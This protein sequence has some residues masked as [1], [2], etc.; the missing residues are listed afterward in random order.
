MS[1]NTRILVSLHV[2]AAVLIT[3]QQVF[4]GTQTNNFTIFRESFWHLVNDQDL[5]AAYP[6]VTFDF[7]KYS[8]TN[9]LLFAPFAVVPHS[10]GVLLWNLTNA[11]VLCWGIVRLLPG[12]AAAWALGICFLE[13]VG[14]IQNGQSNGLV[15]GL[16]IIGATATWNERPAGAALSIITGGSI[17]IF[18]LSV[19]VFGLMP[20]TRWKFVAWC[21]AFGV[22][23]LFAP[24]VVT[25]WSTL[26]SQ[27]ESWQVVSARDQSKVGMWWLGGLLELWSGRSLPHLPLQMAGAAWLAGTAWFARAH[28]R[29]APVTQV[30]TASVLGF[31]IVFNHMSESP[32]FVIGFAGIGIWWAAL[33]RERWRDVVVLAAFVLGSI[34]AT[35]IVPQALQTKWHYDTRMK[36]IVVVIAWWA[37]QVDL[38][39]LVRGYA[40]PLP[41]DDAHTTISP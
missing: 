41:A 11:I 16:M 36:A 33:P 25:S 40:R 4:G 13:A 3:A 22:L 1:R 30:L 10:V 23:F 12:S 21:A 8:P 34:G 31:A 9:A 20:P 19:G 15:A 14:A 29:S 37:M 7:F 24:L 17:K 27:Y 18:P 39:R 2:L 38:W 26:L 32:T 5:Y 6:G 35:D 28:W